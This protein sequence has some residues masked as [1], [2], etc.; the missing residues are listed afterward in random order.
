M[1]GSKGI[2]IAKDSVVPG[3][4]SIDVQMASDHHLST[5]LIE[6]TYNHILLFRFQHCSWLLTLTVVA[7][8]Y[9]VV[10][11]ASRLSDDAIGCHI[12]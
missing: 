2:I 1:N 10:D 4:A 9:V 11:D 8:V 3:L 6:D 7:I 5:F 12:D